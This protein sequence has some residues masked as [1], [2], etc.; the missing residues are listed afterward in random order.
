MAKKK[1]STRK[2]SQNTK[3][4]R[5]VNP[6]YQDSLFRTLFSKP[7]NAIELYNAL[8][9]THY[10][11]DTKVDMTTL[12]E[13]FFNDRKNDLSFIIDSHYVV[14]TEHQTTISKNM[15][16]RFLGYAARTLEK[17]V[18]SP[19]IYSSAQQKFPIPEFYVLYTGD[20][21][22][23]D[24]TLRLSDGFLR[25]SDNEEIP[26][27]SL[28]LVVKIIDLRYNKDNELIRRSKTLEG[29]CRLIHYI[30]ENHKNGM[31]REASVDAAID[32]CTAEGFLS[33]FLKNRKE[34]SH[35]ILG[36]KVSMEEYG[37]VMR[38][39][40]WR[41]GVEDGISQG[42]AQG[43]EQGREQERSKIVENMKTAGI[44]DEE[45]ARITGLSAEEIRQL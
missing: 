41:E 1:K 4:Q 23:K 21:P 3:K 28:E 38:D 14:L 7:E 42:L 11:P 36:N 45:I 16:L 43:R 34:V 30:K 35:M 37:R 26:E 22:W 24:K 6:K 39:N 18:S 2:K 13:I 8:E 17:M 20:R 27:N 15:P 40:G 5:R 33:E 29:Y 9:G 25:R 12:K 31:S 19:S 10:G 32:R 44:S